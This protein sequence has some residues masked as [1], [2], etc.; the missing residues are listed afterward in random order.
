MGT[1]LHFGAST[2]LRRGVHANPSFCKQT[3][4]V[5]SNVQTQRFDTSMMGLHGTSKA[6]SGCGTSA[7]NT[8]FL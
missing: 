8:G 1:Q 3:S 5:S 7:L 4:N 6:I 2:E